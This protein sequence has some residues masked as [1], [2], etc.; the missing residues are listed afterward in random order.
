[1]EKRMKISLTPTEV[2]SI[3]QEFYDDN[4]DGEVLNVRLMRTGEYLAEIT[5]K[6]GEHDGEATASDNAIGGQVEER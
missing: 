2:R 6:M 5:V 4:I 1:M 3:L